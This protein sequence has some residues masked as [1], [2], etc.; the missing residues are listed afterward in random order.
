M[1]SSLQRRMT[2]ILLVSALALPGW[3]AAHARIHEHLAH[4]HQEHAA[5]SHEAGAPYLA[6][7]ERPHD[8]G[9][10][11]E[12]L[13]RASRSTY[14]IQF[15]ALPSASPSPAAAAERQSWAVEAGAPPRASP[16]LTN[17]S[18]PRAPP[19]A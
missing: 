7:D 16:E 19:N 9:H 8:H 1:A 2:W 5:A 10:L 4:H 12:A 17:P 18:R 6:S 13:L 3:A 11:D 14:T 15:A